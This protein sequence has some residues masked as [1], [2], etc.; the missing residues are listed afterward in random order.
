MDKKDLNSRVDS[1]LKNISKSN[2]TSSNEAIKPKVT[3]LR[4]GDE[5]H[6][7]YELFTKETFEENKK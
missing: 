7:G 1:I 6:S 2:E 3:M 4:E 5:S